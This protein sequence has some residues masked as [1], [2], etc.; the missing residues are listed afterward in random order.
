MNTLKSILTPFTGSNSYLEDTLKLVT[1]GGTVETARRA[2]MSA[3][4]GFVDSFFLTAHFSEEDYPYDWIMHWLSKQPA[5]TNCSSDDTTNSSTFG[6]DSRGSD[7]FDIERQDRSDE[8]SNSESGARSQSGYRRYSLPDPGTTRTLYFR[9]HWLR[10]TR[11]R[12][13][14]DYG[15]RSELKISVVA[16]NNNILKQFVD[17]TK[18]IYHKDFEARLQAL[19]SVNALLR[20]K[21]VLLRIQQALSS[22]DPSVHH[23]GRDLLDINWPSFVSTLAQID[24]SQCD[25]LKT[26]LEQRSATALSYLIENVARYM[27]DHSAEIPRSTLVSFLSLVSFS[28]IHRSILLSSRGLLASRVLQAIDFVLHD[29]NPIAMAFVDHPVRWSLKRLRIQLFVLADIT[30]T[31]MF[32]TGIDVDDTI[33][34]ACGSYSDVHCGMYQG[35]RVALKRLRTSS[36]QHTKFQNEALL[37]S[38]LRNEFVLP[39]LGVDRD[40]FSPY[41]AM[42]SPWLEN[43]NILQ[44]STRLLNQGLAVPYLLWADEAA[45]GM[46]YL[47]AEGLVHGDL[48]GANVLVDDNYHIKIADFGLSFI[49]DAD[50]SFPGSHPGGCY[51]SMAPELITSSHAPSQASDVYAFGCL[52]IEI[53]TGRVPFPECSDYQV[54]ALVQKGER[55]ERPSTMSDDTMWAITQRCLDEKP[56]NRPS[57]VDL[58]TEIQALHISPLN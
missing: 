38:S 41:N 17:E 55:P 28:P 4:N 32:L 24:R 33:A 49:Y 3:W 35:K 56:Y 37:W 2:S 18:K 15:P 6:R 8:G 47:H 25:E 43:G 26:V 42:V 12:S 36:T 53:Y 10:I 40:S 57:F 48:R 52:L 27:N 20:V 45:Q 31:S 22:D 1:I 23:V 19:K 16:R 30:P 5:W 54:I 9:G 21:L 46:E 14:H 13:S 29:P 58:A 50:D 34:P 7:E 11:T 39:L 44:G 51:R